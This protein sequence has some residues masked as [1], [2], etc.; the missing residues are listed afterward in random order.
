MLSMPIFE[1]T[2]TLHYSLPIYFAFTLFPFPSVTAYELMR[3]KKKS[4]QKDMTLGK[5]KDRRIN[6][7]EK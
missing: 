1:I 4:F 6:V 2:S 7:L 5:R 3:F